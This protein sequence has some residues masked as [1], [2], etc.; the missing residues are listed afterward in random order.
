MTRHTVATDHT[1]VS[2][3]PDGPSERMSTHTVTVDY[4]TGDQLWSIARARPKLKLCA[5]VRERI[6]VGSRLV[7][8]LVAEGQHVYGVTSGFGSLC[9]ERVSAED[10]VQLQVKH[11]LSHSCGVGETATEDVCRLMMLVKLLTFRSGRTGVSPHIVD[12]LVSMWNDD[13][14]P[15]VPSRGT[16]G[17]SGDLAPLAHAALPLLGQGFVYL[18][19][20][21]ADV[22]NLVDA[23]RFT[24]CELGPKDGLAL[25]NGVQ[26]IT[27]VGLRALHDARE[28]T[29]TADAI[30]ALSLQGFSCSRTFFD[31]RYHS[32]TFHHERA[33]VAENLRYLTHGSNHYE[34]RTCN[35]SKQDPYSFRCLPQVHAAARQVVDFAMRLVEQEANGVSDNPL[36][37]AEDREVLF[38]GNLHGASVGMALDCAAIAMTDLASISERR[39]YQ[40]LSGQRGLPSFLVAN[41]GLNSGFMVAQYTAAALVNEMKVLSHPASIDTIPTCQ[42]QEDHVS[43]GGTAALKLLRVIENCEQV[44]AIELLFA[45]QAC[46]MNEELQLSKHGDELLQAVRDS[47]EYLEEDRVLAG[48][49]A[50][51]TRVVSDQRRRW[52][53][54]LSSFGEQSSN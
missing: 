50:A 6:A 19:G 22:R 37:F 11:V 1:P 12:K 27:A 52:H 28:L 20:E 38:G 33:V 3:G 49:I 32:T 21:L 44:L 17:A 7:D 24:T 34:L 18:S 15:A 45:A 31:A 23:G 10:V 39:G 25:T 46:Q 41:H 2:P 35:V 43:M 48:D 29:S 26:Y 13:V 51:C 16:V 8:D 9:E 4:Y 54:A 5:D 30:A 42:L 40:L 53:A 36:F 47:V 14:I